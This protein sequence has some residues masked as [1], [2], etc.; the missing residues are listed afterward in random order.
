MYS[1][2]EHSISKAY[3]M[4]MMTVMTAVT[5]IAAAMDGSSN[6]MNIL[7]APAPHEFSIE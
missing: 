4:T 7:L 6:W 5:V 3:V 1:I 2:G